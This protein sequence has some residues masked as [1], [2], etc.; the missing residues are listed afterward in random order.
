MALVKLI[1]IILAVVFFVLNAFA[2]PVPKLNL[3][4]LGLAC[5]A[6]AFAVSWL[7]G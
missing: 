3:L 2:V 1:L 4:A 6:A 5:F 7:G